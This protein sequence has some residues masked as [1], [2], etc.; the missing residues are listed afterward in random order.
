MRSSRV[1]IDYV[2][3]TVA[4]LRKFT[5]LLL[6][7]GLATA[8]DIPRMPKE[9]L[10]SL[11]APSASII[12]PAPYVDDSLFKRIIATCGFIRGDSGTHSPLHTSVSSNK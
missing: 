6:L 2:V 9:T 3:L 4:M 11:T 10:G 12:T 7:A 8:K 5:I 1:S